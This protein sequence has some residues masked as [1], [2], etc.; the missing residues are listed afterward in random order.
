MKPRTILAIV[1]AFLATHDAGATPRTSRKLGVYATR[2]GDPHPS[3]VGANLAFNITDGARI[4][5]GIGTANR[6]ET[7]DLRES[8]GLKLIV[9]DW[10]L[11]PLAGV[12]VSNASN[13]P[14]WSLGLDWQGQEGLNLGI[15]YNKQFASG[16][17][18]DWYLQIG[19]FF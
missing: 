17:T 19:Y 3:Y 15:G 8:A 12:A 5:G 4:H 2:N 1:A 9:P 7:S 10:P 13:G 6:F 16:T 14:Y 18:G 11:S